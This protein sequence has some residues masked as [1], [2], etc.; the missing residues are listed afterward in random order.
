MS[1]VVA[2]RIARGQIA[3]GDELCQKA[4]SAL[5]ALRDKVAGGED[6]GLR[7]SDRLRRGFESRCQIWMLSVLCQFQTFPPRSCS[8]AVS[9]RRLNPLNVEDC[10]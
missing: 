4:G 9:S 10:T 1:R 6:T 8:A 5:T 3:A 7:L 2:A